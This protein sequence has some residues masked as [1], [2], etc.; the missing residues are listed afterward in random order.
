MRSDEILEGFDAFAHAPEELRVHQR[1]YGD[2]AKRRWGDT[3]A[4]RESMR[5]GRG[6]TSAEW[7]KIQQE[8]EAN[9][10]RMVELMRGGADPDGQEAMAGAEAMRE[11][12]SR[13][14]YPCT[15]SIHAGLA[16]MYEADPRFTAHYED[17]TEGF[18]AF[19]AAAIR[20]N[21]IRAWDT[22]ED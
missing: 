3:A 12:I 22:G 7:K 6:F 1:E 17:R 5:R 8:A 19:V 18:A 14:F 4:Y 11:H 15:Y 13:W 21:A 2:E 20:A 10:A 16:D 9:E